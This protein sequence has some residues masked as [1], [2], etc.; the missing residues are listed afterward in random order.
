M[1]ISTI[2]VTLILLS[3]FSVSF[4]KRKVLFSSLP[5][6]EHP[7][8]LQTIIA[9]KLT[10]D[11]KYECFVLVH[12]SDIA[13]WNQTKCT[14]I[15]YGNKEIWNNY[16]LEL[17]QSPLKNANEGLKAIESAMEKNFKEFE[18]GNIIEQ[19][20]SYNIEMT[21]CDFM[22][23]PCHVLSHIL[24]ISS[25]IT[26]SQNCPP[27]RTP[28][29]EMHPSYIPTWPLPFTEAMSLSERLLNYFFSITNKLHNSK[30]TSSYLEKYLD[31]KRTWAHQQI[32]RADGLFLQQ[33]VTGLNYAEY[34]PPNSINIGAILPKPPRALPAKVESFVN[35]Y[36]R[37]VYC[38]FESLKEK[39]P[40]E[41][42]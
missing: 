24:N 14:Q 26:F 30:T 17:L 41:K 34:Q 16:I 27:F 18:D 10:E 32:P 37:I 7:D 8:I 40:L 39:L 29:L 15:V 9:N 21:F 23:Q 1:K 35:K 28:A 25:Q 20:K 22:S 42:I 33:C 13:I 38:D 31:Q 6:M 36:E 3:S 11:D 12:A 2:F 4:Q 19:I 5:S